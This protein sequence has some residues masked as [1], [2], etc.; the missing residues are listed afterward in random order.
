MTDELNNTKES[1]ND[2]DNN[3]KLDNQLKNILNLKDYLVTESD[4]DTQIASESKRI[5]YLSRT[6]P[7]DSL[8]MRISTATHQ[9]VIE[10]GKCA[11]LR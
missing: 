6:F 5:R 7:P 2:N 4:K 10:K 8:N 9:Q 3:I 1:L 11:K